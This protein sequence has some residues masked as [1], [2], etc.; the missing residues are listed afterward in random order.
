MSHVKDPLK[1][2]LHLGN[3]V[4]MGSK[5]AYNSKETTRREPF[6]RLVNKIQDGF[7]DKWAGEKP[8][9]TTLFRRIVFRR[10]SVSCHH[11]GLIM[12]PFE[13]VRLSQHCRITRISM[14]APNFSPIMP[15]D[16]SFSLY[17]F[18]VSGGERSI[19]RQSDCNIR[20]AAVCK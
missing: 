13:P 8:G 3:M 9:R 2:A 10:A 14:G 12:S 6:K 11:V 20:S 15:R 1:P 4:R 18:P 16:A 5:E 19:S 7:G 17:F